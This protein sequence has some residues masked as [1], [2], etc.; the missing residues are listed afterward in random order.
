MAKVNWFPGHMAKTLMQMSKEIKNIDM[1]IY[2]LDAR[3]PLSCL[4]PKFNELCENKPILFVLN[5]VDLADDYIS[6]YI[7][8]VLKQKDNCDCI[9][10]NS[11]QSGT[12]KIIEPIMKNLCKNKLQKYA[13]KQLTIPLRAMVIG[14]PNCGKSTLINNMCGIKKT[15]TGDKAGVTRGK[16]WVALKN[17]FEILDTP[18][19]LWPN[20]ENQEIAKKLCIIG[21]IKDEIVDINELSLYLV[22]LLQKYYPKFLQERYDIKL[23]DNALLTINEIAQKKHFLIKGGDID[24]DRTCAM[25]IDDFRKGRFGKITLDQV[26]NV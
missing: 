22:T 6:N 1:I 7:K 14:V 17:G 13:K 20:L 21:S 8:M 2:V 3:A 23:N 9:S 19:T 26:E 12:S 24:Y 5:K 11:I 18:G 15:K 16:Q 10:L 4:N 25:I